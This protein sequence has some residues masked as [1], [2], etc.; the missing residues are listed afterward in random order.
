MCMEARIHFQSGA[1]AETTNVDPGSM[2]IM[3]E[4]EIVA[5]DDLDV[6][7]PSKSLIARV[8]PNPFNNS[9]TISMVGG[10]GEYFQI[11]IYNILGERIRSERIVNKSPLTS[12][13]TWN[14]RD[15][16]G[17]EVESGIYLIKALS[18]NKK[19]Q[20]KVTLLK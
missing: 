7:L 10:N 18:G 17:A 12:F 20:F 14:G 15:D 4:P 3:E 13:Y 5:I 11:R 6:E 1:V 8:Y 2:I 19:A 16:S 9:T